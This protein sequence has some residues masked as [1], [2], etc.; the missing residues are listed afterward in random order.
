MIKYISSGFLLLLFLACGQ[1]PERNC[2]DFKTSINKHPDAFLYCDPPYLLGA[3]KDKL[4]GDRGSTH[5]GFD[6]RALYDILSQRCG[7]VLSYNDCPEIRALYKNYEVRQAEWAYGMKN[8]GGTKMDK[9]SEILII[10][11]ET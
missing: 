6:H 9:S 1:P 11:K 8:V 7:W 4:Y 5:A 3:D 2:E 10:N